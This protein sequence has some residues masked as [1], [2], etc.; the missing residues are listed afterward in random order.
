MTLGEVL[1]AWRAAN[2]LTQEEAAGRCPGLT[3]SEWGMIEKGRRWRLRDET[4]EA[5]SRGTGIPCTRL[6]E[7]A[8]QQ[9]L[10]N[11]QLELAAS[12]P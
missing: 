3:R 5:I 8:L 10:R 7:A 1:A 6:R 9:K 11:V 12:N 4:F 2:D